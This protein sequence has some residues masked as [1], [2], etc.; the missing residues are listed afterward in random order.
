MCAH[1]P[2][3]FPVGSDLALYAKLLCFSQSHIVVPEPIPKR[4]NCTRA[5]REYLPVALEPQSVRFEP[6]LD[7]ALE[8][9]QRPLAASEDREVIHVPH[10]VARRA[11]RADHAVKRL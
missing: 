5:Q 4:R 8:P 7:P 2:A 11:V 10:I 9:P 6:L 1:L 3:A